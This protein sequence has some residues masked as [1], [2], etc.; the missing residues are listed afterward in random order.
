MAA[1]ARR[2]PR[3]GARRPAFVDLFRNADTRSRSWAFSRSAAVPARRAPSTGIDS[4]R[5]IPWVFAW[6]QVRLMLPAWLGTDAALHDA[7]ARNLPLADMRRWPFYRMQM[8]MLEMVLAKVDCTLARYYAS[9]LT[10]AEQQGAVA[11]LCR[12][13]SDLTADLLH[14]TGAPHLLSQDPELAESLLVR[15]T[16]LDPL[17]LLQAELLARWRL[18]HGEREDVEQALQVTMAGIA[19]GLRNTG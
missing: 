10:T 16:Y 9:R 4:L 15:N 5:A 18:G 1:R 19:S 14:S 7:I 8:D 17:H 3:R 6:T 13:V 11:D 12:R 2:L